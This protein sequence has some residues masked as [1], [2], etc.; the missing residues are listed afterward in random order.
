MPKI[1]TKGIVTD[2]TDYRD[3]DRMLTLF[4]IER[5][6]MDV[7]APGCRKS[8]SKLLAGT[9]LFAFCE[10]ELYMSAAGKLTVTS[11]DLLESFYSIR[12]DY[13]RFMAA[14]AAVRLCCLT[15]QSEDENKALFSLL[16][17]T[18]SFLSYGQ[19]GPDNLFMAFL[20]RCLNCLG[21]CPSITECAS[22]GKSLVS[23]TKL[24]FSTIRGGAC[25]S[26]CAGEAAQISPT[27]LEAMR[28][29][30]KLADNELGRVVLKDALKNEIMTAL[31]PY[32]EHYVDGSDR[33]LS[34]FHNSINRPSI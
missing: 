18:L 22:C 34:A 28:R 20:L 24:R 15:V 1:C 8:E 27:A 26:A 3:S 6:R 14:S 32:C 16:Y 29:M 31:V 2:Y 17:H 25:C 19:N 5:G 33:I 4:T 30:L 23:E 21:L 12:E 7:K 10:F 9:Q 11:C 13:E